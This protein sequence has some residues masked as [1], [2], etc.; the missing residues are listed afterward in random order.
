MLL[1]RSITLDWSLIIKS[2]LTCLNSLSSVILASLKIAQVVCLNC[3]ILVFA[4]S[5]LNIALLH[6]QLWPVVSVVAS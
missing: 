6:L 3:A 5:A 2:S 4:L 1:P